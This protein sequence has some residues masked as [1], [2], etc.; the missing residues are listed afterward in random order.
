MHVVEEVDDLRPLAEDRRFAGGREV[1]I[2]RELE[3]ASGQQDPRRFTGADQVDP[4]LGGAAIL[5]IVIEPDPQRTHVRD[6]S[7]ECVFERAHLPTVSSAAV[8]T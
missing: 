8:G 2:E 3:D 5:E 1:V 7:P 4:A 6:R